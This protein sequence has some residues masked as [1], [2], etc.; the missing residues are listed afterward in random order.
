MEDSGLATL[1]AGSIAMDSES[2]GATASETPTCQSLTPQRQET[3]PEP[4]DEAEQDGQQHATCN[5]EAESCESDGE[6]VIFPGQR[7]RC[8]FI[9]D[10]AELSGSDV[11]SDV[12]SLSSA[13]S[14]ID[15]DQNLD[16]N[17]NHAEILNS[18]A[19]NSDHTN[20]VLRMQS[21]D[22][23]DL[24]SIDIDDVEMKRIKQMCGLL[25]DNTRL[26]LLYFCGDKYCAVSAMLKE[27]EMGLFPTIEKT[28][29]LGFEWYLRD[30]CKINTQQKMNAIEWDKRLEDAIAIANSKLGTSTVITLKSLAENIANYCL[31]DIINGESICVDDIRESLEVFKSLLG[32]FDYV[33]VEAFITFFAPRHVTE[34]TKRKIKLQDTI[35]GV[36]LSP[37]KTAETFL[38]DIDSSPIK[39]PAKAIKR[40]KMLTEIAVDPPITVWVGDEQE[41]KEQ[42]GNWKNTPSLKQVVSELRTK[43]LEA[44]PID[45]DCAH[46][47]SLFK[48]YS[49]KIHKA[50]HCPL[51][52]ARM[53]AVDITNCHLQHVATNSTTPVPI[54]SLLQ[55]SQLSQT[56]GD[57]YE[58]D[59]AKDAQSEIVL[60]PQK[61]E[62]PDVLHLHKGTNDDRFRLLPLGWK[63]R[64]GY[65]MGLFQEVP[66]MTANVKNIL[67]VIYGTEHIVKF[68][69]HIA[70]FLKF[71]A[72]ASRMAKNGIYGVENR[73]KCK[74]GEMPIMQILYVVLTMAR[75]QQLKDCL[76][77]VLWFLK[78]Q[79]IP[80]DRVLI[81]LFNYQ[82]HF[83]ECYKDV[84]EFRKGSLDGGF[85]GPPDAALRKKLQIVDKTDD[86][87]TK[88]FQ[89]IYEEFI[90]QD[91]KSYPDAISLINKTVNEVYQNSE[92]A[93][94]LNTVMASAS[95]TQAVVKIAL[96]WNDQL[97]KYRPKCLGTNRGWISY[98]L[99][100]QLFTDCQKM[101]GG[102]MLD[103]GVEIEDW[104]EVEYGSQ[105]M[106]GTLCQKHIWNTV[107]R[108]RTKPSNLIRILKENGIS[109]SHFFNVYVQRLIV[110]ER[111]QKT[112]ILSGPKMSGKTITAEAIRQLHGGVRLCLESIGG[113]DFKID[114]ATNYKG[115]VVVEDLQQTSMS[116]ADKTLR[117]YLDGDTVTT[118]KKMEK[119]GSGRWGPTIITTNVPIDS[120]SDEEN[121]KCKYSLRGNDI[122]T[123][124]YDSIKFRTHLPTV[125]KGTKVETIHPDDVLGLI[126][127]YGLFPQCNT[128]FPNAPR[129]AYMPCTG[130][131]FCD[132]HPGCRM[133][134]D[135]ASN[136]E[137]GV[138]FQHHAVDDTLHEVYDRPHNHLVGLL[139]DIDH[140]LDVSHALE[141]HYHC[142]SLE[143]ANCRNEER[144]QR[145]IKTA[146]EISQFMS[147][148]WTPLT[149]LSRY[150]RGDFS[151]KLACKWSHQY[152]VKNS[153]F[154]PWEM[155][156]QTTIS[157]F[158]LV[159]DKDDWLD[160]LVLPWCSEKRS[161]HALRDIL[162]EYGDAD[163]SELMVR[164]EHAIVLWKK[165]MIQ[166]IR[167]LVAKTSSCKRWRKRNHKR[168]LALR[169]ADKSTDELLVAFD[170]LFVRLIRQ[171]KHVVGDA[172]DTIV[173]DRPSHFY[174]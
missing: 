47:M 23:D 65:P 101:C 51:S 32:T 6:N 18:T 148:V 26:Q 108:Y 36:L 96:W 105:E 169:I 45:I 11:E 58:C 110:A 66:P 143:I 19:M 132:H 124:R 144:K 24:G 49:L 81:E 62:L 83:A 171:P 31:N 158:P 30:V 115:M 168:A 137:F 29:L 167:S 125:L 111:R 120:D 165:Q 163:T 141:W 133:V 87:T 109:L 147:K 25:D 86:E 138:K 14:I 56:F 55:A 41:A 80:T 22:I 37:I 52:V 43:A 121:V 88:A 106:R 77:E 39:S 50:S 161:V 127:R 98:R 170:A 60:Y 64:D 114:E 74:L 140:V 54:D 21:S 152:V 38:A 28:K 33:V 155:H 104:D 67:L 173:A 90:E 112:V 95:G 3:E 136:L 13:A 103:K 172:K 100:L 128:L 46:I 5:T 7:V 79:G 150:L 145:L 84:D 17:I 166:H 118:N 113:R 57:M 71:N 164:W 99:A 134:S 61:E 151:R 10:E 4:L 130:I 92:F 35:A 89:T 63:C 119:V 97:A 123:Y 53:M 78:K 91:I 75:A 117:P 42:F 48:D 44:A 70:D 154:M 153:L 68:S 160:Y 72:V 34:T 102:F 149:Y 129:C 135:I 76:T 82:D 59:L 122:F 40:R 69:E 1:N 8:R 15:S 159:I 20:V 142:S 2:T 27:H 85:I 139:F 116:Y 156:I 93:K 126:W 131:T 12:E 107:E 16:E 157:D 162:V 9:D 73:S 174:D 94:A 146:A